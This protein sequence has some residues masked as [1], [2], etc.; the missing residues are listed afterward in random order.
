[1]DKFE[2]VIN[3]I[4]SPKEALEETGDYLVSEFKENF[5]AEGARLGSK[6]KALSAATLREKQRLGYGGQPILV[7]TGKMM[8][9]FQKDVSTWA[10]RVFNPTSYF[11]YHQLG[12]P[13]LPQRKMIKRTDN[14]A[15]GIFEIINQFIRRHL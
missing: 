4:G 8:N 9:D 1:M 3:A 5:P 13:H 11:Q 7:R 10:V 14:L 12:T 15:G 6:W 2:E